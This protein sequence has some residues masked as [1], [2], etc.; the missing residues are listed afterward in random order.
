MEPSEDIT[1]YKTWA[2]NQWIKYKE[3]YLYKSSKS[4]VRARLTFQASLTNLFKITFGNDELYTGPSF[5]EAS[6]LY[7]KTSRETESK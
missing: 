6:N 1:E 4:R 3:Q 2:E 7:H 5:E